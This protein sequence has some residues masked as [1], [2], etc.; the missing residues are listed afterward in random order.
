MLVAVAITLVMMAAVVT[1]FANITNSVRNRRAVIEMTGQVRHVRNML[2]QDLAGATC[3]GLT[4]Q[5]PESNHGY[6]ELSEGLYRDTFP[7][8]LTDGKDDSD[9]ND[10]DIDG[11]GLPGK[12]E[13][14]PAISLVPRADGGVLYQKDPTSGNV[15]ST[16][17][18]LGDYDDIL[19][20]T[21]RNEYEPFVGRI[22]SQVR[23]NDTTAISFRDW[24]SEPTES[25]LAE[26][27]W[28]A[29]ENPSEEERAERYFGEPGMRTIYRR[30]LL[31]A[32][33]VNPYRF[34][35]SQGVIHDSFRIGGSDPVFTAQPGLVR[36][37]RSG[38]DHAQAL[39]CLIAF[40]ER[41]DLSVRLEFDRLMDAANGGRWKIVANTLADLTKRENRYEHHFLRSPT[42]SREYPYAAVSMGSGYSGAGFNV[43]FVQDPELPANDDARAKANDVGFG[44]I[45]SYTIDPDNF[46]DTENR[47]YSVRP[48]AYVDET[49][50][51]MATARALL[52][53]DGEVVRVIHGLSPLSG[54]R[55]GEDVMLSDALA[56]DLR[57]Y[58]PGAP[59]YYESVTSTVLGPADPGWKAA[60]NRT[61]GNGTATVPF[62][63]QGSYVDMGYLFDPLSAS[64]LPAPAALSDPSWIWPW[65]AQPRGVFSVST[66]SLLTPGYS[67]YDT[68]TLHYENNGLND[69]GDEVNGVTGNWQLLDSDPPGAD[70]DRPLIDEGTN[71]LDDFGHYPA[72]AIALGPDD[73][74][75]RETAPPYDKPLRGI[76]VILRAYER[77][78]RQIRQVRVN[79]HFMPE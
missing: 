34:V 28:Y 58:D 67:L 37:L 19:M 38:I 48:F 57:V 6:I 27:I 39:A 7:S 17:N 54:K 31:I 42:A 44:M 10:D 25:T 60:Y 78:S 4:W 61:V 41:Y 49:S 69:D 3:P 55:R 56:F 12:D 52:N 62:V 70:D 18:A 72:A 13:L 14:D 75:E 73:V 2:Q 76:Q 53:D 74:G 24:E 47:R 64:T 16:L 43:K 23:P 40:Q 33:W 35:D 32:P 46:L 59:L 50:T 15:T 68:W 26:I 36:I 79:Q 66:A 29:I 77:D 1:L 8:M 11:D 20:F 22:P 71:G 9:G 45:A 65:F 5:E 21:S 51:A 30:A 63:G